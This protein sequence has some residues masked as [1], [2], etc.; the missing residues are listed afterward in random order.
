MSSLPLKPPVEPQLARSRAGL[1]VGEQW[2]YEPKYDGFRAIVFV[3]EEPTMIQSRSGKPLGRYFPELAFPPGRYVVDG[4]IVIDDPEGGQ[5]FGAL[6]QR[7]HP[8]KSR[9]DMLAVGDA[10][11]VRRVRPARARRTTPGWK[12]P[13]PSAG[14]G[15]RNCARPASTAPR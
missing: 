13:S 4:E 14:R 15:S 10:V 9:I 7:I 5:D 3:D 11:A 6:Q 1:P 12:S 2:S 8:A